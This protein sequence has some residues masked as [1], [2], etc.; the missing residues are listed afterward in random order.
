MHA[1]VDRIDALIRGY[2]EALERAREVWLRQR[3]SSAEYQRLLTLKGPLH[4][5]LPA[6]TVDAQR[7]RA[8]EQ[9]RRIFARLGQGSQT[10]PENPPLSPEEIAECLVCTTLGGGVEIAAYQREGK[11]RVCK[12]LS[13]SS[14]QLTPE[15]RRIFQM[16]APTSYHGVKLAAVVAS[17][18]LVRRHSTLGTAIKKPIAL[19]IGA[20]G[21]VLAGLQ[22]AGT[23]LLAAAPSGRLPKSE[24]RWLGADG[25]SIWELTEPIELDDG[26]KITQVPFRN[27][28]PVFDK[29]SKG[30]VYIAITGDHEFDKQEAKRVWKE[31]KGGTISPDYTFHHDGL[32]AQPIKYR[33]HE[34]LIG[35]MQLVPTRLN[36]ISHIGSASVARRLFAQNREL[37][38]QL[39]AEISSL[40]NKGPLGKVATRLKSLVKAGKKA[41]RF[42]P[43]V[44][45][46]LVI[47]DFADNAEAHGVGGAL[48]RSTPL[49]GDIVTVYD[50]GSELAD[51]IRSRAAASAEE[52]QARANENVHH[53]HAAATA[54]TIREFK[55]LSRSVR[56]TNPYFNA[57][58][59]KE[60]LENYH[61]TVRVLLLLQL[62][63]EPIQYPD[64]A[65]P[66]EKAVE[67]PFN[68]KLRMATEALEKEIRQQTDMPAPE[69]P[70]GPTG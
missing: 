4:L 43:I 51:E 67:S 68:L 62:E 10:L 16:P 18:I 49:L 22:A 27:G 44:G 54:L 52:A 47:L 11:W 37:G 5:G 48:L 6:F 61:D 63:K 12:L 30:D 24:G 64:S 33:N 3:L 50:M 60:P 35:R 40:K 15:E 42:L 56:V 58:S 41:G 14:G 39:A 34:V 25:N 8:V 13:L 26:T 66:A 9:Q 23:L 7:Q 19:A 31:T 17:F 46:V 20:P 70:K 36:E 57:D 55:R 21:Y 53:A 45:G 65:T 29:W 38:K 59:L 1:E 28:M 69:N 32:T 2:N